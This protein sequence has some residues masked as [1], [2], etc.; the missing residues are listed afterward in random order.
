MLSSSL[1]QDPSRHRR[2]RNAGIPSL[3]LRLRAHLHPDIM[4]V[5]VLNDHRAGAIRVDRAHSLHARVI[6]KQVAAR[7]I[8]DNGPLGN[9]PTKLSHHVVVNLLLVAAPIRRNSNE[10][11]ALMAV[12]APGQRRA[13]AG[14]GAERPG[15]D[16]VGPVLQGE[17]VEAGAVDPV[18]GAHGRPAFGHVLVL[19]GELVVELGQGRPVVGVV[20]GV[21]VPRG[22][23][24]VLA[25]HV[26]DG[27]GVGVDVCEAV[28]VLHHDFDASSNNVGV[29]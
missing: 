26:H 2:T 13:A 3:A 5:P 17:H 16:A 24:D 6:S 21:A 4:A 9:I 11:R 27:L 28:S 22:G 7:A 1:G 14:E 23:L 8:H 18:G 12:A 20:A 29:A 15:D 10:T 19:A 25:G